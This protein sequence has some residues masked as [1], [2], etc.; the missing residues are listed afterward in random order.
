MALTL[1]SWVLFV[2]HYKILHVELR[3]QLEDYVLVFIF[4]YI[5]THNIKSLPTTNLNQI[6]M[7]Y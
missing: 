6:N 5:L 3:S 4:I 1:L 2:I 7:L